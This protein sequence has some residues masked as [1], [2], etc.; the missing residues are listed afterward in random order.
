MTCIRCRFAPHGR[1][2]G[3]EMTG[4]L[5]T[6]P[7]LGHYGEQNCRKILS[8]LGRSKAAERERRAPRPSLA[9]SSGGGASC[10]LRR[11]TTFGSNQAK[12]ARDLANRG[13]VQSKTATASCQRMVGGSARG[14]VEQ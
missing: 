2:C 12:L 5:L 14:A 7:A 8:V 10:L 1:P 13:V 11:K 6:V 9:S 3:G 4:R